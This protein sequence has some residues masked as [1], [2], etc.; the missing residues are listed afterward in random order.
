MPGEPEK[1]EI[2]PDPEPEA[3]A[4]IDVTP[5]QEEP[6]AS[7]QAAPS[8]DFVKLRNRMEYQNRQLEKA[9]RELAE[10]NRRVEEMA[11]RFRPLGENPSEPDDEIDKVA[12]KDWKKGVKLVMDDYLKER[13]KQR[14]EEEY[15]R[16]V[17]TELDASRRRVLDRYPSIS[18]ENSPEARAYID[19]VN[20]SPE[21]HRNPHGPELAMYRMEERLRRQKSTPVDDEIAR[22]ARVSAVSTPPGRVTSTETRHVLTQSEKQFCDRESI[23]YD[24]Y[25]K[26]REAG[27]QKFREGVSVE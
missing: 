26:N 11:S 17:Q 10:A 8:E 15:A 22:R 16:Q 14:A 2:V 4:T 9:S 1:V 21:L 18:D 7:V 20:E 24:I 23:P 25:I 19:I 13:E 27:S 5:K 3:E 6:P 12:V